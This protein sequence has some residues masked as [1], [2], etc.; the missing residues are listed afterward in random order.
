MQVNPQ[1]KSRTVLFPA[2]QFFLHRCKPG[3]DLIICHV[4]IPEPGEPLAYQ[5]R[6]FAT[7]GEFSLI[8]AAVINRTYRGTG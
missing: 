4:R 3:F 5:V 6:A 7:V 2:P 1:A 8:D